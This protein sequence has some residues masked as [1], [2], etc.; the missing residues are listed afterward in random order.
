MCLTSSQWLFLSRNFDSFN[1][2]LLNCVPYVLMCQRALRAYMPTC[3]ACFGAHVPTCLACLRAHMP[4]CLACLRAQM[5]SCLACLRAHVPSCLAYL[6]AHVSM[7]LLCS[8]V[9]VTMCLACLHAHM[10]T[11]SCLECACVNVPCVLCVPTCSCAITTNDKHRFSITWFPN[12]FVIVL[13]LF[14][15]K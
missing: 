9:H 2:S 5:P 3:L 11:G 8:H 4:V 13:C 15:V 7:C 6:H 10:I 14:P 12:V 1:S